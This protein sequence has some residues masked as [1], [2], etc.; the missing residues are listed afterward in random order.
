MAGQCVFE[1][2]LGLS[3]AGRSG[4]R[5]GNSAAHAERNGAFT[6]WFFLS[7]TKQRD[8]KVSGANLYE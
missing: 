4:N 1:E 8:S 3:Q 6:G 2:M 5:K 7:L